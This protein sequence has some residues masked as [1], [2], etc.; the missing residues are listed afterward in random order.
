MKNI[1][2]RRSAEYAETSLVVVAVKNTNGAMLG[3]H[4]ICGNLAW[5]KRNIIGKSPCKIYPDYV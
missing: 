2:N 5:I 1:F 3:M 4:C